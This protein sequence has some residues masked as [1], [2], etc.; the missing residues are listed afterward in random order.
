MGM[1][2]RGG[3]GLRGSQ[4]VESSQRAH[5][6]G[7]CRGTVTQERVGPLPPECPRASGRGRDPGRRWGEGSDRSQKGWSSGVGARGGGSF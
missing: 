4:A 6:E 3:S 5:R 1:A 2:S 7:V